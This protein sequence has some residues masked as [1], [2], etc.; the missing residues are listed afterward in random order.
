MVLKFEPALLI[1]SVGAA[2]TGLFVVVQPKFVQDV[3]AVAATVK[4]VVIK[5]K[6]PP[7]LKAVKVSALKGEV[8]FAL[9]VEIADIAAQLAGPEV[10]R[11]DE[12]FSL[13]KQGIIQSTE[14]RD[15][16]SGIPIVIIVGA[17]A[18]GLGLTFVA[19]GPVP[20]VGFPALGIAIS[21]ALAD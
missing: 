19:L 21:I 12:L 8:A 6:L 2:I 4:K 20:A 15:P 5:I 11:P 7:K 1:A 9:G 14:F 18:T 3:S 13:A 16:V 17:L 10:A